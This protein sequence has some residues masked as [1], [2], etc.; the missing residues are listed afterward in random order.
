M[1]PRAAWRLEALG[2]T[3]VYDYLAGKADWRAAGLPGE[4]ALADQ[5]TAADLA[6]ASA[7]TCRLDEQLA[8]VRARVRSSGWET[9][10]V[11]NEERVVLGRFG[12]RALARRDHIPVEEAMAEGP[13]TVRPNLTL[14]PL[15]ERLRERKLDTALVT[16]SDGRLIGMI[17]L[18]DAELG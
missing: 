5:P 1:S 11:V 7:P 16:T 4:G 17:R 6:D 2:F 8:D 12:Q 9:C 14:A 13:S 18:K 10:I 15:L 3:N